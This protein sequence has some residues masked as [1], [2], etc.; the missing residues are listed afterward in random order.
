M[1]HSTFSGIALALVAPLATSAFAG[2]VFRALLFTKTAGFRHPSI[3]AG[4][5]SMQQLAADNCFAIEHTEDAAIFNPLD[6]AR[7]DVVVFLCTSGDILN[8]QQQLDFE[9]YFNAGGGWVGVHSASDTEYGW[10][11]YGEMVGAYFANHPSIQFANIIIEDNLHP[12]TLYLPPT[13]SRLDEWYNFRTNPRTLARVLATLDESTYTGGTMGDHPIIWCREYAGG[14]SWYTAGGH[15]S[16][17]YSE[18]QFMQHIL[19]GM[20]WAAGIPLPQRLGDAD[21]NGK[22]DFGD[23]TAVLQRWG[24]SYLPTPGVGLGDANLDGEVSFSD[25]TSILQ[26]WRASCLNP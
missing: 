8:A 3:T 5:A 12:S 26:N 22:V 23:I 2:D 15:T 25:I 14:R 11:F 7:F 10:P 20:F 6:L 9:A 18:R 13:W 1:K 16:E 21:A 17:S 4:V 24:V 19:G